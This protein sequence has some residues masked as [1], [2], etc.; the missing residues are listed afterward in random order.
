MSQKRIA[1]FLKEVFGFQF[2]NNTTN[3]LKQK[4]ALLY[5][6]TYQRLLNK[7]VSGKLVQADE[8]PVNL[9]GKTGYVWA[10]ASMKDMAYVYTPSREG[11]LVQTLLKDFKGV[12]ITTRHAASGCLATALAD[13]IAPVIHFLPHVAGRRLNIR[14]RRIDSKASRLLRF[15]SCLAVQHLVEM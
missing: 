11:A 9:E 8:T 7:V 4:A 5:K 10:F 6:P 12:P 13:R 3:K 15:R 2:S 1:V 14:S